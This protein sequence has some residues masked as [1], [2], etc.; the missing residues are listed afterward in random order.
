MARLAGRHRR[1]LSRLGPYRE[2]GLSL[3]GKGHKKLQ[4]DLADLVPP[5]LRHGLHVNLVQHGRTVCRG[6]RGRE[7]HG[8]VTIGIPINFLLFPAEREAE[9]QEADSA[10]PEESA[11]VRSAE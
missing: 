2:L 9:G 4:G 3:E 8:S 10:F 5:N 7:R 6:G 11:P 1:V